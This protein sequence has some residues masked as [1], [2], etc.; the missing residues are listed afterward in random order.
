LYEAVAGL[1]PR[2]AGA[3]AETATTRPATIA[4]DAIVAPHFQPV[5]SGMPEAKKL[6]LVGI[7]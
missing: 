6:Q 3:V 7:S 5:A 2:R 1:L 4:P